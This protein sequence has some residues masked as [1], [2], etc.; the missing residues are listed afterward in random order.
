MPFLIDFSALQ[1]LKIK[2]IGQTG[3][4]SYTPELKATFDRADTG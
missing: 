2:S 1:E 4:I 3:F